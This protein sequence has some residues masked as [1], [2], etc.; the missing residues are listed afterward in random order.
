MTL[1]VTYAV[2]AALA[3]HRAEA[4]RRLSACAA[5]KSAHMPP[6][7][8]GAGHDSPVHF[9]YKAFMLSILLILK[10]YLI[11]WLHCMACGILS[12]PTR[13]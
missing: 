11:F 3:G 4:T 1:P 7:S 13:D 9:A 5:T 10:L 2:R 6:H 12:S 8:A